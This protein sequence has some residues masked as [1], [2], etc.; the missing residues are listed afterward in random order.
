MVKIKVG[1]KLPK[2]FKI[3]NRGEG[4]ILKITKSSFDI[5]ILFNGW[6]KKEVLSASKKPYEY[7]LFIEDYIIF[8]VLKFGDFEFEA[9]FNIHL[10]HDT[11][12]KD[13]LTEKANSVSIIGVEQKK[14]I[15]KSLRI[16][17][18]SWEFMEAFKAASKKQL[19]TYSSAGSVSARQVSIMSKYTTEEMI[20]KTKFFKIG[21]NKK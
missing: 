11:F 2:E 10:L 3:Y 7:G 5:L 12:I 4:A 13:W 19:E 6:S 20:S 9:P 1:E 15:V 18:W 8:I 21:G 14:E 17:G 16:S